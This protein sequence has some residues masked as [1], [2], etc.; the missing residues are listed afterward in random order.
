MWSPKQGRIGELDLANCDL[1]WDGWE[2]G[3]WSFAPPCG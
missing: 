2:E 1:S 3:W